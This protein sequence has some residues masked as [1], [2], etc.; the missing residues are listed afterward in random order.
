MRLAVIGC[1][2]VGL[3]TGSCLA[4]AAHEVIATD[5]DPVRMAMLDSGRLPIYEPGLDLVMESAR[6]AG[7]LRFTSDCAQAVRAA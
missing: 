4:E 5:N 6:A 3:V 1:G 2:Y 7:R